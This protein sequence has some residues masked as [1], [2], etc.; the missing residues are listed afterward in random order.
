MNGSN[1]AA[2]T[3]SKMTH[4]KA[5]GGLSLETAITRATI[6]PGIIVVPV[7]TPSHNVSV[8]AL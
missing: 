7:T 2:G 4:L 3:L 8:G 6:H 5:F 1:S